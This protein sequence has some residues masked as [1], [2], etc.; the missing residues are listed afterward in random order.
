[1]AELRRLETGEHLHGSDRDRDSEIEALLVDGLDRYFAGRYD[2]AIHLWTR[3]LFLDRAHARAR[4]YIDRARTAVAERQ[5]RADELLA[6]SGALLERGDTHAARQ[7][8]AQ[9]VATSGEDEHA[10]ALRLR[11]ERLERA[12]AGTLVS[13]QPVEAAA[14]V[15]GWS[16]PRRSGT[17]VALVAAVA[18]GLLIVGVI[19]S[20][21][22][23]RWAGF[24][25]APERIAPS[26]S[27][28]RVPV[29]SADETAMVRARM[30]YDRGRL[31]DALVALQRIGGDSP[32][33]QQADTLRIDIQRLLLASARDRSRPARG[34]SIKR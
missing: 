4:A 25:P 15:P 10:S 21:S 12:S 29:L 28:Q 32:L 6:A 2:E 30:L 16:W 13:R 8:L 34:E 7:L 17:A 19:A 23:Q 33:R 20:P 27:P 14:P 11:L 1:M 18:A 9:A 26:P 31:P 24:G 3:V 5:R 22:I